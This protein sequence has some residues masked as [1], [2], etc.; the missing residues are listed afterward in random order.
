MDGYHGFEMDTFE[1][2]NILQAHGFPKVMGVLT[3]LD[4]FTNAKALRK[5]KKT[6]KQRFWTEIYQVGWWLVIVSRVLKSQRHPYPLA[7]LPFF[8]LRLSHSP[9]LPCSFPPLPSSLTPSLS[10]TPPSPILSFSPFP[11]TLS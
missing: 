8:L 6:L 7:I 1:F 3:H 11:L 9:S 10:Y 2:L 4:M 5:A